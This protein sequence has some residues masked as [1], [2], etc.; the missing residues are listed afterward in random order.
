MYMYS[1]LRLKMQICASSA[2]FEHQTFKWLSILP[3]SLMKDFIEVGPYRCVN[4]NFAT[5]AVVV[6]GSQCNQHLQG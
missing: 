2:A 4:P 5:N 1:L 3:T 6:A